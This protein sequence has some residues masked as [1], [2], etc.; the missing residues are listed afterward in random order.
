MVIDLYHHLTC[1]NMPYTMHTL[2]DKLDVI[3]ISGSRVSVKLDIFWKKNSQQFQYTILCLVDNEE[4]AEKVCSPMV[5]VLMFPPHPKEDC[6][7]GR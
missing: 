2:T 3:E 1:Y 7:K 5:M 6:N 4:E